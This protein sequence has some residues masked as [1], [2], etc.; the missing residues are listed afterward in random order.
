NRLLPLLQPVRYANGDLH[1]ID[2][3]THLLHL[4]KELGAIESIEEAEQ[5]LTGLHE[6]LDPDWKLAVEL[7]KENAR[8]P[9]IRDGDQRF[10]YGRM[11]NLL[12]HLSRGDLLYDQLSAAEPPDELPIHVGPAGVVLLHPMTARRRT[13]YAQAVVFAR[14]TGE[15]DGL[16]NEYRSIA[17][18]EGMRQ[19]LAAGRGIVCPDNLTG[20]KRCQC[21]PGIR[22]AVH[23]LGTL[24]VNGYFG[25]GEWERPA[26]RA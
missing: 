6:Q 5:L 4:V 11:A 17:H 8:E 16:A 12:S 21:S 23:A 2:A 26:C 20:T 13:I 3:L 14:D 18:F 24:A 22:R 9:E 1:A 10:L 25:T 7:Q 19:Q 15:S